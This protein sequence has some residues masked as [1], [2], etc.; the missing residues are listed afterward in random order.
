MKVQCAIRRSGMRYEGPIGGMLV[1][2]HV[3][4]TALRRTGTS[5][6]WIIMYFTVVCKKTLWSCV[7]S[8]VTDHH[9]L[10]FNVRY[11]IRGTHI[12][13]ISGW[14]T[15]TQNPNRKVKRSS[16]GTLTHLHSDGRSIYMYVVPYTRCYW[17][18]CWSINNGQREPINKVNFKL[19]SSH[20]YPVYLYLYILPV[21]PLTGFTI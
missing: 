21:R 3:V 16:P 2:Y 11:S 10:Y 6:L 5:T 4:D 1:T 14:F 12:I 8:T 15:P 20:W 7:F 17:S 9:A 19:R 18:S 13:Y